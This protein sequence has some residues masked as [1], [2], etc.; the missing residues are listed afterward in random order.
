MDHE[1]MRAECTVLFSQIGK[2]G[3]TLEAK[4]DKAVDKLTELAIA[5]AVQNNTLVNHYKELVE[6]GK[7]RDSQIDR[8]FKLSLGAL[9][10]AIGGGT[11]IG[12]V[13]GLM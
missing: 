7:K 12:L 1:A 8:N 2:N 10:L 11:A 4:I 3:A 9:L 5:L 6:L 13:N